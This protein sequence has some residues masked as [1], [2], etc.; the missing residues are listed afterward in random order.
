[1]FVA[2]YVLMEYG[3]GAIMAVPAHDERDYAFATGLRPADPARD[4]RR[5]RRRRRC[6]TPATGR[7]STPASSTACTTA[8][9]TRRSSPGSTAR[10][11]ATPRSTT[12]CATGC[13]PASATGAARSRSSTASDAGWCRCPRTS[14]RSSC[15]TSRTTSPRAA[16]RWPPPR[17]GST[18]AARSCGGPARRETDTMDTFVDSSWYFLRYCDAR[19]DEAAWDREVLAQWMPVDQY[20]GGVEHAI[21]HLMYARFFVKALADMELLDVQEPFEALFTQGMILGPDGDKMSKSRGNVISPRRSS[22]ATAPTPRAATSCSSG[23]PT[24]TPPGR[25]TRS[26]ACTRFLARLW[27]LGDELADDEPDAR[28]RGRA[29]DEPDGRRADARPQGQLGDRQ[30]HRRHDG[31]FAFNTA[32]AAVMELV[33]ELYRHAGRRAAGAPVRDRHRRLAGVPVRAAPRRRG[34]RAADRRA[35]CGRSRGRRPTRR[36]SRPTRS[37][38]SARSTARSATACSAPTGAPRE[39]L[40][41]ARAGLARRAGPPR[42]PRDRQG[43]RRPG[44][45]GQ[46]RRPLTVTAGAAYVAVVGPG[47]GHAPSEL[48]RRDEIG[49]GLARARRGRRHRR[50]AAA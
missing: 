10:A 34:L 3:T 19:N 35:G 42:R 11:R 28:R 37:S 33:N 4:R 31:R 40:E 41:R 45:A 12:A 23:R 50:A 15:P 46:R 22:S 27:R 44:Q 36:C 16:R 43:D 1:M 32:I 7:W 20:I 26:R 47:A 8:R 9:P 21:L 24:R 13:S 18:R 25:D 5:G 48:E 2:D 14:C 49:R 17:T 29:A 39:E 30:G 6:R 38:S